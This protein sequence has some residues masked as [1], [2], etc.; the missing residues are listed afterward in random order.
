[1]Q[2]RKN[3]EVLTE[4][5][6]FLSS[7]R[8]NPSPKGQHG[9]NNA[10]SLRRNTVTFADI[11]KGNGR[12][13]QKRQ[14]PEDKSS[15][16]AEAIRK[17]DEGKQKI[18][19][20]VTN[21][22]VDKRRF[23]IRIQEVDRKV[24]DYDEESLSGHEDDHEVYNKNSDSSEEE[25]STGPSD[26]ESAAGF[27]VGEFDD[28]CEDS[29]IRESSPEVEN[30]DD[31]RDNIIKKINDK[32]RGEMA[33]NTNNEGQDSPKGLVQF[34]ADKDD[35][36]PTPDKECSPLNETNKQERSNL[37][38]TEPN[39][40]SPGDLFNKTG[41]MQKNNIFES[42][43]K[44]EFYKITGSEL[45]GISDKMKFLLSRGTPLGKKMSMFERNEE[46]MFD[47]DYEGTK[48]QEG[49]VQAKGE[50]KKSSFGL[51][52]RITRSQS[53]QERCCDIQE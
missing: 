46:V 40:I 1:M 44:S 47:V 13:N 50:F 15:I 20:K 31:R 10:S 35:G 29:I 2:G 26:E 32:F 7:K 48:E 34:W 45:K 6:D 19:V 11:V 17:T 5:R 53:K 52:K 12:E 3:T 30:N 14:N 4:F 21:I 36:S 22:E 23:S 18:V 43:D 25:D 9:F 51:D 42:K 24:F 27:S 38:G 37:N 28:A 16:E 49:K 8:E 33:L 39:P 41:F